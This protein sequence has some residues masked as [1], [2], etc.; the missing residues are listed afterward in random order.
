MNHYNRYSADIYPLANGWYRC[1][2]TMH[3]PF[4]RREDLKMTFFKDKETMRDE[5]AFAF[6]GNSEL[7]GYLWG[8]QLEDGRNMS[9]YIPTSG[10]ALTREPYR[11]VATFDPD[12]ANAPGHTIHAC[13]RT[14]GHILG[15]VKHPIY[16]VANDDG[17]TV[18]DA[19]LTPEHIDITRSEVLT[20]D[21]VSVAALQAAAQ[22][23][24]DEAIKYHKLTYRIGK[25]VHSL[26][27][28]D[29]DP[30]EIQHLETYIPGTKLLIGHDTEGNF[31]EGYIHSVLCYQRA[32]NDEEVV[33]T[34]GEEIDG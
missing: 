22:V 1:A 14:S 34:H 30:A 19:S 27:V 9:P 11:F 3:H 12:W 32:L 26:C 20:S 29:R 15:D 10:Q 8:M 6:Q 33:F 24:F 28:E 2:L 5:T 16:T 21:E 31:L 7:L 13:Y 18:L 17:I 4:G 25:D 23:N